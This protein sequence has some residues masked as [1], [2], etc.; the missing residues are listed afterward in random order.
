MIDITIRYPNLSRVLS[1]VKRIPDVALRE[2]STV[3][4]QEYELIMTDSELQC[5][6]DS[7]ALRSTGHVELPTLG[8]NT[9]EVVGGYG[10]PA[11]GGVWVNAKGEI[12]TYVGYAVSV[13]EDLE[14]Y[15]D[16]GNAKFLERPIDASRKQMDRAMAK[17]LIL[18]LRKAM[19]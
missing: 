1:K 3:A 7:G 8:K 19:K 17:A 18:G 5:P 2:L 15:H 6:V 14:A 12:I 4:Y 11:G 13:H 16:D 9:F 10:G